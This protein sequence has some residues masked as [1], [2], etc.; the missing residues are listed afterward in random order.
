MRFAFEFFVLT[1]TGAKAFSPGAHY[2]GKLRHH[3]QFSTRP[4]RIRQV[5]PMDLA[6]TKTSSDASVQ[7]PSRTASWDSSPVPYNDIA[8]GVPKETL[9]GERR[10]AQT[11]TSV[12]ALTKAGFHVGPS[13][14][15]YF[16]TI[17]S[18]FSIFFL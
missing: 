6:S 17:C 5:V 10:V 11:P 16:N 2:Q 7:V 14:K 18:L 1:L 13:Q 3:G 9:A 8:V 12:A 4:R 15:H